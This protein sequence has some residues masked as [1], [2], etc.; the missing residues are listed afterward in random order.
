M[1]YEIEIDLHESYNC[2]FSSLSTVL[3]KHLQHG[4]DLAL[5]TQWQFFFKPN[6]LAYNDDNRFVGECPELFHDDINRRILEILNI[7]IVIQK[8]ENL[9]DLSDIKNSILKNEASIVY[10][11]KYY[12]EAAVGIHEPVHTVTAAILVGFDSV[13]NTIKFINPNQYGDDSE[14]IIAWIDEQ[15][16]LS[17][18]TSNP[19]DKDLQGTMLDFSFINRKNLNIDKK[20]IFKNAIK[21]LYKSSIDFLVGNKEN[22]T[23]QG[24]FA[25]ESFAYNILKWLNYA[26]DNSENR[27]IL[28]K[29]IIGCSRYLIF[30]K[31]IMLIIFM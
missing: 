18:R 29:K 10:A 14:A 22:D 13:N 20:D 30:V 28:F 9:K 17:A 2:F 11:D 31:N 23:L 4:V 21:W 24:A 25:I 27:E 7:N 6:M 5:H 26:N 8:Y 3:K 19:N 1:K 12:F 15:D 16:L